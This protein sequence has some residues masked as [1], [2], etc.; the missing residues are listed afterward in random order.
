MRLLAASALVTAILALV[1]AGPPGALYL[2]VLGAATIAGWPVGLAL[3]GRH[4]VG[5]IC[6]VA[7]GYAFTALAVWAGIST[8]RTGALV[9]V[10]VW[11]A[12]AAAGWLAVRRRTAPLVPMPDWNRGDTRALIAVLALTAALVVP[13]FARVGS[14]DDSGARLYRAYF[15]AD[16]VW[17]M[18][19]TAELTKGDMPPRNPYLHGERLHYYWTYFLP[20]AAAVRVMPQLSVAGALKVTALLAALIF[21][22]SIFALVWTA[23]PR[24]PVVAAAV[25][26]GLLAASFEGTY[27]LYDLWRR[28]RP[29]SGVTDLNVDAMSAWR[30]GGLRIDGLARAMWDNPQHSTALALALP[31]LGAVSSAG[32][33]LPVSAILVLGL[34]LAASMT[35]NPFV[36]ALVAAIYGMAVVADVLRRRQPFTLVLVHAAAA[37]P[38]LLALAW[39]SGNEVAEGAGGAVRFGLGGL[40][41]RHPFL[42]TLLS[43]GPLLAAALPGFVALRGPNGSRLAPAAIGCAIVFAAMFGM[44]LNV[45]EAWVGFRTGH[46]AQVL[47]M[48]L[49]AGAIVTFPRT[50]LAG[51]LAVLA[52]AGLPTTMIDYWNAQDTGNRRM[53]P[54]F[55]WTV[56]ISPQEHAALNWIREHTPATAIVQMDAIARGRETW[57]LIPS[58]AE[59]R[60]AAGLPISL[61]NV[62]EYR[63][64]SE[65]VRAMYAS[66]DPAAAWQIARQ[67]RIDFVYADAVERAAHP[68]GLSKFDA[69]PALFQLVTRR[70]EASVWKVLAP[71]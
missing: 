4:P 9:S 57:S 35:F 71:E 3:F 37:V 68:Q 70:G 63:A 34:S 64:R 58:F 39:S 44:R 61:L 8:G 27:A 65:R 17:H 5:L 22:S 40:A 38:M 21:I 6:G 15:T 66:P 25:G 20:P 14:R 33:A 67:L 32:A 28:D 43:L 62:P 19:L 7:A 29:L 59:R 50:W 36:G 56:A 1:L 2:L 52:C 51:L 49:V 11:M 45:D 10:L 48:I 26:F 24:G 30:L 16:F 47:L 12:L 31:A 46:I 23:V 13:P 53:G 42:T 54:G 41:A 69:A 55:R 60:M 18:G